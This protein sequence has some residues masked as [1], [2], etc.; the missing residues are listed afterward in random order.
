MCARRA[1]FNRQSGKIAAS[2]QGLVNH[3]ARSRP[4]YVPLTRV[5]KPITTALWHGRGNRAATARGEPFFSRRQMEAGRIAAGSGRAGANPLRLD[6]FSLPVRF[7]AAD[8]AADERR[9]IVDLHRERV[10]V[11]RSVAGMRMALNM[12]VAAYRGVAIRLYGEADARADRDRGGA[13]TR[14][15]GAVA[16]ALLRAPKPTTSSPNGRAGAACSACRFWSRKATAAC[17][18]RSRGSAPCASKRRPGAAAAAPQ[19][20]GAGRRACCAAAPARFRQRR[21][22]IATS[23]RSSR[24]IRSFIPP[25]SLSPRAGRGWGEGASPPGSDV[26]A[27]NSLRGPLTLVR[28]AHSTSP[29]AAG[30]GDNAISFSRCDFASELCCKPR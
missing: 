1:R 26:S 28:Y 23:A 17:A 5:F 3:A 21:P 25:D 4:H 8:E 2:R 24:G 10:V 12:P 7:E 30:R 9:R 11:R 20:P 15:S 6:P 19:S 22:C 27:Q 29:R 13:R 18:S 14:R 16:A